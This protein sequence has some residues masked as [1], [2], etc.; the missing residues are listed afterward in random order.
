M[1]VQVQSRFGL[2]IAKHTHTHK[3]VD[4][5]WA[6]DKIDMISGHSA[7]EWES[8]GKMIAE[9]HLLNNISI[10]AIA[11]LFFNIRRRRTPGWVGTPGG[12]RYVWLTVF[13][14]VSLCL[15]S[16]IIFFSCMVSDPAVGDNDDDDDDEVTQRHKPTTTSPIISISG[17]D[18]VDEYFPL[19]RPPPPPPPSP[20]PSLTPHLAFRPILWL[21]KNETLFSIFV[22]SFISHNITIYRT[23]QRAQQPP[24]TTLPERRGDNNVNKNKCVH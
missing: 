14:C 8:E 5:E 24:R 23:I 18:K 21:N 15:T 2:K 3:P 12:F 10:T 22:A 9:E 7:R 19:Y 1:D 17:I 6:R 20:R 11:Q 13:V 16:A 4:R